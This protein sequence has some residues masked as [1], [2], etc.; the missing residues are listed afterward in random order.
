MQIASLSQLMPFIAGIGAFLITY[1][2]IPSIIRICYERHLCDDPAINHRKLHL[3][4]TPTLGGVAIFA[5]VFI[6][7]MISTYTFQKWVPFLAAGLIILFFSGI[8]DDIA[9]ISPLKKLILQIAA[10]MLVIVPNG[11]VISNLGGVF[12]IHQIPYWG[13]I[14]LTAFTMI[15]VTNAYNLIDGVDG[16][17]GG[18]G[19]IACT[20]FAWWFWQAGMMTESV[21]AITLAGS[22][23]GFLWYNFSPASIFM[24][25]TGSQII[26]FLLGFLAVSL[27]SK[28]VASASSVPFRHAVPVLVLAVLIVPLYD[29]L[30][31]FIIRVL[32]MK[33]PF[34]PDRLHIHHQLLDTGFNHK[35]TCFVIY[36]FN[37][38]IIA[39]ALLLPQMNINMMLGI[40]LLSA[41]LLFPTYR[42]K[43]NVLKYFGVIISAKKDINQGDKGASH[44]P[45]E[46]PK[47]IAI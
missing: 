16:L 34:H 29:T 43:R 13:G 21:L 23:I 12:G 25:D 31:I 26:G 4:A 5:A 22:L 17:A 45:E 14:L 9:V 28:G 32:K 24:G 8:K 2:L 15:V 33:S 11:L 38:A 46:E 27:V 39:L 41:I 3:H 1:L 10:I 19:F 36:G 6:T 40:V 37:L 42:L 18:V 30:R 7:F 47:R 20:F 44:E 35:G